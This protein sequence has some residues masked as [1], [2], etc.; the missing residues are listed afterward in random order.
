MAGLLINAPHAL[1]YG[2]TEEGGNTTDS[3]NELLQRNEFP[4][5]GPN[6]A[7]AVEFRTQFV[8][9]LES[10]LPRLRDSWRD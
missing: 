3:G 7:A 4:F 6:T 1:A 9:W 2:T 8:R 10:E 5:T